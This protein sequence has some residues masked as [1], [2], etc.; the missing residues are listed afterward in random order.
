MSLLDGSKVSVQFGGVRALSEVDFDVERGEVV[1]L[2]GPNGA[3]KTTLLNAISGLCKCTGTLRFDGKAIS[4]LKPHRIARMGIARTFQVVRPFG[5]L[6]AIENVAVG[7]MF[8]GKSIP[9]KDEIMNRA[10]D[11]LEWTGLYA[12]RD[13]LPRQL[14]LSERQRLEMARALAMN[15]VLLLL[16]EVM[17][18]LNLNEIDRMIELINRINSSLGVTIIVVEHVMKAIMG[19]CSRIVVLQFGRKIG[20]GSPSEIVNSPDVIQAYLGKRF[21]ERHSKGVERA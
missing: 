8:S 17:A 5:H 20:D 16:D 21:A 4:G 7:A 2:I 6:T 15:P 14:T 18:G 12:K 10:K 3:G 1:G 13:L 11:A 9:H 19:V